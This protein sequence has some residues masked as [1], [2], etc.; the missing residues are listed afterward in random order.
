MPEI[1]TVRVRRDWIEQQLAEHGTLA[2]LASRLRLETSTISRQASGK[3]EASPRFIGAV[4]NAYPIDFQDAFDVTIE[5]V[6][7][8]RARIVK[9]PTGKRVEMGVAS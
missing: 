4:L 3:S 2:G 5:E 8:R 1:A 6:A 7:Q 9:R